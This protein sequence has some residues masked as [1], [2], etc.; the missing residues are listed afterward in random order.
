MPQRQTAFG[1]L[2]WVLIAN[3]AKG[4]GGR[5]AVPGFEVQRAQSEAGVG[6]PSRRQP[7][8]QHPIRRLDSHAGPALVKQRPGNRQPKVALL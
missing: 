6:G 4:P 3:I 5:F 7:R 1:G 2:V 8:L